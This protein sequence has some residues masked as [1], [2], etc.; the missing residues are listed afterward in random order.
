MRR[1]P[2]GFTLTEMLVA[3]VV[4]SILGLAMTRMLISDTRFVSK[5]EAMMNARQAARAA[6]NTMAVELQMVS[7]GGLTFA[8]RT[9]L[10]ALVPYAFGV[11]CE[12]QGDTRYA[13]LVP[14]D[15][16]MYSISTPTG[17]AWRNV[18]AD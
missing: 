9:N 16:L 8:D 14:T 12:L 7:R 2:R 1:D 11:L 5:V 17:I 13:A 10:Q 4:M 6:M 3:T 18:T 15:S